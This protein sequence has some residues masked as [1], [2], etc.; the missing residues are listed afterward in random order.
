MTGGALR[1]RYLCLWLPFL[2]SDRWRRENATDDRR[3]LVFI[4]KVKGASRLGAVDR[5]AQSCGLRAGMTLTDAR[6][7]IPGLQ[8]LTHNSSADLEFLEHLADL[9]LAFTPSVACEP[10]DGL[11]LD[12]TGCAH[13]FGGEQGLVARLRTALHSAGVSMVKLAVAPTPDM[14]RALARFA[15]MNPC[16][17]DNDELVRGL[18]VAALECDEGD[19]VALRRAGLKT[20][21]DVAD[22][23]SV[24]FAAR[25]SPA[26]AVKLARVLGE[27]DR[28][29]TPRRPLPPCM[30]ER[31]CAEPVASHDVVERILAELVADVAEQ[32]CQRGE[33]GRVF[34][35][36][37]MRTDGAM[38][39]I[40]VETSQPMR[41][42]AVIM[43]LHRDRLGALADPLDPGFGFDLIRV[44]V[45][46]AE[47]CTERQTT[48]DAH[49][50]QNE[51]LT[52]L[53]DRLGAMFGRGRIVRLQP[54]DSHIPERAQAV[55]PAA[56]GTSCMKWGS[57]LPGEIP[58]R[59][60]LLYTRAQSIEV[61]TDDSHRPMHLR[62]R[63]MG[64]VI[65]QSTGPERIANEWWRT[66]SEYGTRDYYRVE[67]AAGHRFWIFR[68]ASQTAAVRQEWF[69]HGIFP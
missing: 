18:P 45:M 4:T 53:V 27:E 67:S 12:I 23:P 39:R 21:A 61:E 17:A 5:R 33:G 51:R 20:I 11:A 32:L 37:A 29:I 57:S 19:T 35:S 41:D 1:R 16:F 56:D 9:A 26:F 64:H 14:A 65:V 8:V 43:R 2:P 36:L 47:P 13:L 68:S 49:D 52:Q 48:L 40:R 10:P 38:R 28:C 34:E 42:P 31:R 60:P 55:T 22:R 25:F 62:W 58:L 66:P 3:P 50:A 59:P 44:E 46:H 15:R 7:R 63:R 54:L 6:A 24:L 69:L 30:A